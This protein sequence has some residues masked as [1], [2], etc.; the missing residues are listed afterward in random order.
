MKERTD[1][2]GSGLGHAEERRQPDPDPGHGDLLDL[3]GTA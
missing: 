2:A 1:V 3:P